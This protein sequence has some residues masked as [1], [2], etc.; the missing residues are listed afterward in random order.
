[1]R[2][3]GP[4]FWPLDGS[5]GWRTAFVEG[6]AVGATVRLAA[7]PAGPLALGSGDG[8]LGQLALPQG[9]ALSE[10]GDLYLLRRTD[11]DVVRFDPERRELVPLPAVGGFGDDDRSFVSPHAIAIAG[12]SLYVADAGAHRVQV[13]E[14]RSLVLRAVWGPWQGWEPVDIS[15]RDGFVYLLDGARGRVYRALAT[16][17]VPQ[18]LVDRP[19]RAGHWTRVVSDREGRVY[20]Y[21][22]DAQTLE[23]FA[24]D[25]SSAGSFVDAGEVRDRFESPPIVVDRGRFCL[26]E[27]LARL[28]DRRTPD[29]SPDP[30][31]PL[32]LCRDADALVFDLEGRRVRID[33]AEASGPR[34]YGVEGTWISEPL[35]S[36]IYACQW[37]RIELALERLPAGTT[38]EVRT[39]SSDRPR[40]VDEVRA[41]PDERWETRVLLTGEMQAP[42]AH[43]PVD[44][45][46]LVQSREGQY[47]WVKLVL[48]GDGYRSPVA[49]ALRVHYPRESYLEYLPA[50]FSA[51]EDGRWFLQRYLSLAQAEW[52]ALEDEV[53]EIPALFDPS[54]VPGGTA[55]EYLASW[56]GLPLEGAWSDSQKRRLLEAVPAIGPRRGTPE[57]VRAYLR[58]YLENVAGES[59]AE[60]GYPQLVEGF[61]ERSHLLLSAEPLADFNVGAPLWSQSVVGRLRT[62]VFAREGEVRLVST[63][64]PEH[65]LFDEY[66]HRFRVFV[67]A[68]WVRTA[69]DERMLRRALDSEKPAHSAYDLCLVEPRVRVGAQST[70]GLDTIVAGYPRAH[71]ACPHETDL[72]AS[73]QP[74]NRL[75]YDT[76]LACEADESLRLVADPTPPRT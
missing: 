53:E 33:P 30:E 37:H 60:D 76:L 4:T 29:P 24:A 54:A 57:G 32:K 28:C 22:P 3:S 47:L 36:Q 41:L 55:L 31:D 68:A 58:V 9:L 40:A 15:A 44:E 12:G 14:T 8:S 16:D 72:P 21:D 2:P 19:D 34:L 62:G 18:L 42:A 61:R 70:V 11:L 10:D 39:Y 35:D 1:M 49:G 6:L 45:D 51:E 56:L 66:A 50:V 5:V 23:A 20:V 26:P 74:R 27:S 75:G 46:L 52:N 25:G 59:I 17:D 38:I 65:D 64:D 69:E 67:P 73:L 13:F 71:L 7:D 48:R 63:G 43:A